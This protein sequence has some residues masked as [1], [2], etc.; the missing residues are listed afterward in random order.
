VRKAGAAE[1]LELR[2]EREDILNARGDRADP[3]CEAMREQAANEL[4][5]RFGPARLGSYEH[6]PMN[7]QVC[8]GRE[9]GGDGAEGG[10]TVAELD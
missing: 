6:A 1:I 9:E 7:T 4:Q 2:K 5:E 8:D 3:A 10:K